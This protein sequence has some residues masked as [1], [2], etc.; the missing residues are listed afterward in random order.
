VLYQ[1]KDKSR[2]AI[3][4][5]NDVDVWLSDHKPVYAVFNVIVGKEDLERK[6]KYVQAYLMG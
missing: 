5:Y 3:I 4:G 1:A 2:I 6:K